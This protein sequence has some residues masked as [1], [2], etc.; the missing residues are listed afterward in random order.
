M[1]SWL[2]KL[3]GFG[4]EVALD[5]AFIKGVPAIWNWL[6]QTHADLPD[7]VKQR[8]PGFLGIDLNDEQIYGGVLGQLPP[9]EQVVISGFLSQ[10]KDYERNRF[11]NVVAGMEVVDEGKTDEKKE[12][13]DDNGKKVVETKSGSKSKKDK[14]KEFLESFAKVITDEFNGDFEKAYAYCVAGRMIIPDPLHQKALRN[15]TE[16]TAWFKNV[17]LAPFGAV[18]IKDLAQKASQKLSQN[19]AN[20]NAS[21]QSFEDRAKAFYEKSKNKR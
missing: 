5:T 3:L 17:I 12:S 9:K 4:G 2:K 21:A 10:C 16:G 13:F 8:L 15:F 1:F 11:I 7:S 18:S 14:R 19:S 20:L 6:K